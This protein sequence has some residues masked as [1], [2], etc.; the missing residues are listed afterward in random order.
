MKGE[1]DERKMRGKENMNKEDE[2][3]RI[4]KEY[5]IIKEIMEIEDERIEK[6]KWE[7]DNEK[8]D[9]RRRREEL[10]YERITRWKEMKIKEEYEMRRRWKE[11]EIMKGMIK[12]EDEMRM[13][14]WKENEMIKRS[15]RNKYEMMKGKM[16]GEDE[17]K[18]SWWK[19]WWKQKMK[20]Q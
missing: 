8:N 4:L 15:R 11:T 18:M 1:G 16:K 17:R 19:E 13:R 14:K 2:R 5:E 10:E 20:G 9:E 6:M 12:W 3:R 7:W